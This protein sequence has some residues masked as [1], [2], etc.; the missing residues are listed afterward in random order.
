MKNV[1][2]RALAFQH[3]GLMLVSVLA[4]TFF[5]FFLFFGQLYEKQQQEYRN[6]T[7]L[8]AENISQTILF[9]NEIIN[10]LAKQAQVIELIKNNDRE[11]AQQWSA[12]TRSLLPYSN[13]LALLTIDRQLIGDAKQQK[14]GALCLR[15]LLLRSEGKLNIIPPVHHPVGKK[16]HFD[17]VTPVYHDEIVI[18]VLFASFSLEIIQ[19]ITERLQ[20]D[21][22]Y[23]FIETEQ[24]LKVAE[25]GSLNSED[26]HSVTNI[27]GTNWVL[28]SKVP[29]FKLENFLI[30]YIP[31]A[32]ILL[33]II[34]LVT[35]LFVIKLGKVII[36]DM[37]NIKQAL[38]AVHNGDFLPG[39]QIKARLKETHEV[40]EQIS[41][42]ATDIYDY[43]QQLLVLSFKDELTGL[44]NRRTLFKDYKNYQAMIKR[45]STCT[46]LLFDLDNFK[47]CN[48]NFGHNFG[49]E[50]LQSF[51]RILQNH[52]RAYDNCARLGGD[53]F[54][55]IIPDCSRQEIEKRYQYILKELLTKNK[56]WK[57]KHDNLLPVTTSA[58]AV[59]IK[60]AD[61]SIEQVIEYADKALYKAKN[62]GRGKICFYTD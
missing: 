11:K 61:I 21:N 9:Y 37:L 59:I 39:N 50:V 10:D 33:F 35:A 5:G 56:V 51:A 58:G 15:D 47:F 60:R 43:Q 25:V 38:V 52:I 42:L 54:I 26:K 55:A 40:A 20:Q 62:S 34:I 29:D 6:K 49:D 17:I 48:D 41:E 18:G 3:I 2:I 44:H 36:H 53:E 24:Q 4:I 46:L 8:I 12:D 32:L 22:E 45:G 14:I 57:E 13:S 27:T 16:S 23:L 31:T 30:T 28:H 7:K 1:S 19:H